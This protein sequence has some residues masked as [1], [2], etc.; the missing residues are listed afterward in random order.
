MTDSEESG[1]VYEL[2]QATDLERLD[3]KNPIPGAEPAC[4]V[5]ESRTH[6]MVEAHPAPRSDDSPFRVRLICR[7]DECRRWLVYNW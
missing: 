5:C 4:P 1:P 6:R 7:N 3:R 2:E